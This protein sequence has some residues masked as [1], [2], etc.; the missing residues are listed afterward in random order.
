[1]EFWVIDRCEEGIFVCENEQGIIR[2]L[3]KEKFWEN[4]KEGDY[5]QFSENDEPIYSEEKTKKQKEIVQNLRKR[6]LST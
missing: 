2:E 3:P 4:A 5:F 6:L 1:M